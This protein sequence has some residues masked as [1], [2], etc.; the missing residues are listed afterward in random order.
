MQQTGE[1]RW[2]FQVIEEGFWGDPSRNSGGGVWYPP[3]I[4]VE[5]GAVYY[6]TGNP[7]P[8]PGT[9]AYPNGSSRPGPNLYTSSLVAL[10]AE[11][12][13]LRWYDQVVEH[14]LFDHDF[15]VPPILAEALID[16][17]VRS[18]VVGAGKVGRVLAFDAESGERVW[19]TAVGIHQNDDLDELPLW[20]AV[21]VYPGI[22]GGVE[23]PMAIADG[24]VFV[25]VVNAPTT[26]TATG[27]GAPDGHS[28]MIH[29]SGN[30]SLSTARGEL[31]ALDLASGEVL[32][33][34]EFDSPVFGG[35]TVVSDLV[36]TATFDGV[37]RALRASDGVE[38]WQFD[39]EGGVNAWPAV[40]GDTI[41]WAAGLGQPPTLYAFRLGGGE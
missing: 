15:Q 5:S 14:D 13:A 20:Q 25:P 7:G 35:A 30:T 27:H 22:F 10:D 39:T 34:R 21:E 19:D 1:E 38:V 26:H 29:A 12:G 28:A 33:S 2:R 3:A 18:L 9:A 24:R 37:I 31:V 17:R 6:G 11:S 8:Y 40:A 36:F 4:D 41:V 32:W 16:G 23:T